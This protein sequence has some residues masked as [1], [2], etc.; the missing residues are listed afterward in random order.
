MRSI[1][2][3]RSPALWIV[4]SAPRTKHRRKN[5][6][7]HTE[8]RRK[9]MAFLDRFPRP[10]LDDLVHGRW[11]PVIGAGM[12]LNARTPAGKKLPTWPQLSKAL[13]KDM[14][15]FAANGPLD[16]ISAYEH[17]FGRARLIE[18]LFSLLL[19]REAVP[20]DAHREFCTLP[21]QIVCTTNFE[22]L[23]EDQYKATPPSGLPGH[24][25]GSALINSPRI[26][27]PAPQ[28]SWRSAP[29]RTH[30]GHG[31]RL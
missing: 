19:V 24:R 10:V 20:G 4:G 27:D 30:R 13:E 9:D 15:G 16:A 29:S 31:K 23:L 2:N 1:Q 8:G 14:K 26:R 17:K 5:S 25:R 11:L 6:W 12:S 18:K 7:G 21:F 22:F 28:A 3:W